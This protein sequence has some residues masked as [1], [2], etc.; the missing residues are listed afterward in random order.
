MVTNSLDCEERFYGDCGRPGAIRTTI[1]TNE[2]RHF[3]PGAG[4]HL[5]RRT[6]GFFVCQAR[7]AIHSRSW[8]RGCYRSL[9]ADPSIAA[10]IL[11]GCFAAATTR[12]ACHLLFHGGL[13]EYLRKYLH[14]RYITGVG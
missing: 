8:R 9:D 1:C 10:G 7:E 12:N 6:G 5:A 11:R 13:T 4:T 3:I 14:T 2:F